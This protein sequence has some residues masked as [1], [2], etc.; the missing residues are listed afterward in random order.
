MRPPKTIL[1]IGP[2]L[3]ALGRHKMATALIVLQVALTLA[4]ASNALFVVVTRLVHLSRPTRHRRSSSVCH[5]KQ[6]EG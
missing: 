4:L 5:Q 3:A 2:I 6:L 1:Q